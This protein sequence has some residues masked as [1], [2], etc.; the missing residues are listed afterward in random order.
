MTFVFHKYLGNQSSL[1]YILCCP[2]ASQPKKDQ[3]LSL[4]LFTS[5]IGGDCQGLD[6]RFES[7]TDC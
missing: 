3:L 2:S 5:N 7:L 6:A 4:F 1:T